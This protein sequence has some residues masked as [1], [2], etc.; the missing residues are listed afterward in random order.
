ML[1]GGNPAHDYDSFMRL[2]GKLEESMA[3][4]VESN[5]ILNVCSLLTVQNITQASTMQCQ[6]LEAL[7]TTLNVRLSLASYEVANMSIVSKDIVCKVGEGIAEFRD[8]V[9]FKRAELPEIWS[10]VQLY[11]DTFAI[12]SKL[13]MIK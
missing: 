6:Y 10:K 3:V 7:S 4:I 11:K 5:N 2:H 12:T 8:Q 13:Y 9:Q 1:Q